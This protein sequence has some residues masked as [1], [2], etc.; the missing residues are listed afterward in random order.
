MNK[1]GAVTHKT[2]AQF[3]GFYIEDVIENPEME[4]VVQ[5][6]GLKARSISWFRQLFIKEGWESPASRPIR[7]NGS[8]VTHHI[9]KL[10]A[11]RGELVQID[12]TEYDWFNDGRKY[13]L[14]LAVDDATTEVL[15]GWFMPTE[16]TRGYARMIREV[17][18]R[19]GIPEAIYSDKDSVFRSVKSGIPS[20]FAEMLDKLNI[21]MVFA[22]S[23]EAKGCI[24]R[25]NGT[26][27]GR[28]P[29]R[30][31]TEAYPA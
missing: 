4:D 19:H 31:H 28:L 8:H 24:E 29:K 6:L 25:Y 23:A 13:V 22:N 26:A 17:L 3:R 2:I 9:R 16:C 15:G 10:R 11:H 27:Q 12:G 20:Q 1:V 14:H 30:Y 21:Q 7:V 5:Q 18:D